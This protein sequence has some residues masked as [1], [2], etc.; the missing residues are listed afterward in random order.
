MRNLRLALAVRT[1]RGPPRGLVVVPVEPFHVQGHQTLNAAFHCQGYRRRRDSPA[2][3]RPPGRL[4]RLVFPGYGVSLGLVSWRARER[5]PGLPPVFQTG[6][7]PSVWA[8]AVSGCCSKPQRPGAPSTRLLRR[9]GN[10]GRHELHPLGVRG[11]GGFTPGGTVGR[12][13]CRPLGIQSEYGSILPGRRLAG[14][15]TG[16]SSASRS[17]LAHQGGSEVFCLQTAPGR[18]RVGRF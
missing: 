8:S 18:T 10:P 2:R 13:S 14:L 11:L 6:R 3:G 17:L 16:C 1:G 7:S 15:H 5:Y 12:R 9:G 4:R